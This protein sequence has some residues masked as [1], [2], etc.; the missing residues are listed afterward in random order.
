VNDRTDERQNDHTDPPKGPRTDKRQNNRTDT[1]QFNCTD[2]PKGPRTDQRKNDRTD[3]LPN[4][5][6]TFPAALSSYQ[7][8]T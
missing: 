8:E 5:V 2:T 6:V 4:V 3:E 7:I 1:R